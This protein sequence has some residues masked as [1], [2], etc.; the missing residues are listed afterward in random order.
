MYRETGKQRRNFLAQ[1]KKLLVSLLAVVVIL[2][3]VIQPAST[4]YIPGM[5]PAVDPGTPSFSGSADPVPAE[6]VAYD[7]TT[8]ML[9]AI[10]DADMAA[11]GTSFW[12]D[13]ILERPG[14][15]GGS[16]LLT[17]GRALYMYSHST[18]SLGFGGGY[19]YRERPTGSNQNMYT[20]SISDTSLSETS[21]ERVQ[22]PS[23]WSSV[24]TATGLRVE[25]KKFISYNDV[26]VTLLNI[27]NN[28]SAETT[29]TLTV[30]SPIASTAS[31]DG[32]ELTGIVNLRYNLS[33]VY[34]R[35]SGE[36]F[37]V[38]GTNLTRTVTIPA[39]E[40]ITVKVQMGV[41]AKEIPELQADYDRFRGYDANTALLTQLREFNQW[42]VDNVTYVDLPDKNVEKMSYYR[43]FLN[44]YDYVDANIPGNDFQFPVSIE[45]I[46]GYNNAIQLTQPMHMQDLKYFRDPMYSYG[47]WVSSGESGKYGPF[48]DNMGDTSHWG[49]GSP[50]GSYEQYIAREAWNT[51]KMHGGQTAILENLA[52]YAEGDV[53]G[54]LAKYDVN[55]NWLIEYASGALTGNDAD[56]V[57]LA[58]Y[59]RAQDRTETAFWYAGA[60]AAAEIYNLLGNSAK[61]VEMQGIADNIQ[62]AILTQLWDDLRRQTAARSSR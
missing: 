43:T 46:L 35:L 48:T 13:R 21:A 28:S 14:S 23:Y 52:R 33:Q 19:A 7:P 47:N 6:P 31:A 5:P 3:S 60:K 40:S 10:Y 51:Y 26:A 12:F 32:S 18:N 58:Y 59:G 37:A 36:G 4:I 49:V 44:R 55:N 34:P 11:G 50:N 56:A 57:A 24:H 62:N 2:F 20:V 45:G 54:Q 61:A 30:A 1:P 41:I 42:W 16:Y 15:A 39:G 22:Y 38:S 25:Q 53:K 29:R 17:K 27:I 8:N 9:Q